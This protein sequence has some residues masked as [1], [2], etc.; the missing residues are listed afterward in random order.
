MK[1][2]AVGVHKKHLNEYSQHVFMKKLEKCQH[3]FIEKM[4]CSEYIDLF[5]WSS[6]HQQFVGCIFVI[7]V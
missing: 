3:F 2:D 1:T 4:L 5:I 6:L 7:S